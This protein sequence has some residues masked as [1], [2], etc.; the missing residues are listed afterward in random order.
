[1]GVTSAHAQASHD[2]AATHALKHRH[3]G[4]RE[5]ENERDERRLTVLR[6]RKGMDPAHNIWTNGRAPF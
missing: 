5:R 6:E 1:M 2:V 3:G 4:G